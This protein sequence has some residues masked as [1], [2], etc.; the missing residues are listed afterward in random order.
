MGNNNSPLEHLAAFAIV[1]VAGAVSA[2]GLSVYGRWVRAK[3][4]EPVG[5][6]AAASR[7][8]WG[9][10]PRATDATGR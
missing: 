3:T 7:E 6:P 10:T 2:V 1:F 8:W 4:K 5:S 9:S